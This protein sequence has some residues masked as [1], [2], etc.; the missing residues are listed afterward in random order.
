MLI[1]N[2]I[3]AFNKKI[4]EFYHALK[5]VDT[6]AIK[7][8]EIDLGNKVVVLRSKGAIAT[9]KIPLVEVMADPYIIPKLSPSQACW[10]GY[11]VGLLYDTSERLYQD[12]LL[13][14][15]GYGFMLKNEKGHFRILSQN[16]KGEITYIDSLT[17]ATQSD[18]PINIVQD[19]AVIK[20]FDSTQACYI[21]MLAGFHVLKNG[22]LQ[23][24]R[25]FKK[26]QLR[27]VK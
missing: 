2:L 9:L 1:T 5:Q 12:Q 24:V 15:S 3:T 17:H 11:Y 10:L 20:K 22:E 13:K 19:N 25:P 14:K 27:V 8:E 16:R 26:V 23:S 6:T 18:F 7:I 4:S 21:G